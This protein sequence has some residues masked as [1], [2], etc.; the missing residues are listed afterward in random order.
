MKVFLIFGHTLTYDDAIENYN[1]IVQQV[2]PLI[3]KMDKEFRYEFSRALPNMDKAIGKAVDFCL[4]KYI[5]EL[6][7]LGLKIF[8]SNHVYEYD[9]KR[10]ENEYVWQSCLPLKEVDD[11]VQEQYLAIL[12]DQEEAAEYRRQRKASRG[13]W[14]GGGFGVGG[15]V[16]GAAAAG[17]A[18]MASGLAHSTFNAIGNLGSA[19]KAENSKDS[20][21]KS[22]INMYR[23]AT[24][25]AME[26]IIGDIVSVLSEYGN[27]KIAE[28]KTQLLP[29]YYAVLNN[30]KQGYIKGEEAVEK[31]LDIL[32]YNPYILE[33]YEVILNV[34]Q[35]D[36]YG[37]LDEMAQ[38][39]GYTLV[40]DYKNRNIAQKLSSINYCEEAEF[41][42][43]ADSFCKWAESFDIKTEP[44]L[45]SFEKIRELLKNNKRI[46]DEINYE[47]LEDAEARE[48]LL[49][50]LILKVSNTS[51]NDIQMIAEIMSELEESGIQSKD[52]YIRYLRG[53]LELENERFCNVKGVIYDN[54]DDAEQARKDAVLLDSMLRDAQFLSKESI[55]AF[56]ERVG[57]IATADLRELY[58]AYLGV[59]MQM[60]DEE[61]NDVNRQEANAEY[62]TRKAFAEVFY[63]EYARM[64]K[65]HHVRTV[66]KEYDEWYTKLYYRYTT[67]N[68]QAC[69]SPQE[70]DKAYFKALEHARG[71]L[72][73]ITEKNAE[74]KSFFSKIKTGVTGIVYKN[75]EAEYNALTENGTKTLPDD[76]I[77]EDKIAI[78]ELAS[79]S[80]NT[81]TAFQN[82]MG[83]KY[84]RISIGNRIADKSMDMGGLFVK[85]APVSAE[86][87]CAVLREAYPHIPLENLKKSMAVKEEEG[88]AETETKIETKAKDTCLEHGYRVELL[89]A[90]LNHSALIKAIHNNT[91]LSDDYIQEKIIMHTP[92]R[93]IQH[94]S[95]SK[96][97]KIKQEAM[98]AGA[99]VRIIEDGMQDPHAD[100]KTIIVKSANDK[101]KMKSLLVKY[102]GID[103]EESE[104]AMTNLPY[105]MKREKLDGNIENFLM[106]GVLCGEIEWY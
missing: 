41:E 53:E 50:E 91:G 96:A 40:R 56:S 76:D 46:V 72:Q 104:K 36:P 34:K 5:T 94:V 84:Q 22:I 51:G 70:A 75:Y 23:E 26:A 85:T 12:S 24:K 33:A 30:I 82:E 105:T 1:S 99:T 7:E 57:N 78:A 58:S 11:M 6:E 44:Y 19:I 60:L 74:K 13:R 98:A 18:N 38:Y 69:N 16:K 90:G 14:E 79:I 86:E 28:P 71:Y 93:I 3:D 20:L 49:K 45:K 66:Q 103:A 102:M 9:A 100:D 80:E 39:F 67:V 83:E 81:L 89:D 43:K 27:I 106:E 92:R 73:Y 37:Y 64:R 59:C 48:K 4:D 101:E 2:R 65:A 29:D 62:H 87:I 97:E 47:T 10:F 61:I 31:A 77:K 68:G 52:K 8:T 63:T 17:A 32:F 55:D 35:E 95:L 25:Q 15:A 54:R 42:D 21:Y 88:I